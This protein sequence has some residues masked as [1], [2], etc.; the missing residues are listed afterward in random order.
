MEAVTAFLV[1]NLQYSIEVNTIYRY[2]LCDLCDDLPRFAK[3]LSHHRPLL[4]L[5]PVH[6]RRRV[7]RSHLEL[8]RSP[9]PHLAL[10]ERVLGT[11]MSG[12][13]TVSF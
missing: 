3:S 1:T 10:E 6:D 2:Q 5:H 13:G 11:T 9:L 4:F 12:T 8:P 7:R